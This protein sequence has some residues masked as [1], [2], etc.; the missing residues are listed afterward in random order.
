[1]F[2]IDERLDASSA[3]VNRK[4]SSFVRN[5]K[6]EAVGHRPMIL[7]FKAYKFYCSPCHRYFNQQFPGIGKHQRATER[8]QTQIFH[9]HAQGIS[10]QTLAHNFRIGKATV[11]RWFHQRYLLENQETLQKQCPMNVSFAYSLVNS[12][13]ITP[14]LHKFNISN[15]FYSISN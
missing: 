10:G 5:V 9:Q 12:C 6:H 8:F 15:P 3:K 1:M 14:K 7:C 13:I 4:K 11:E 2:I